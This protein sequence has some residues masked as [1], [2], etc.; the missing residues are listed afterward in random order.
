MFWI[1]LSY[2]ASG[3]Y[4]GKGGLQKSINLSV[5]FGQYYSLHWIKAF[6]KLFVE[7]GDDA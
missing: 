4:D 5:L 2:A 1:M 6:T 7:K 3:S